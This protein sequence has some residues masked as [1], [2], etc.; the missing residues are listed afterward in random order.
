[1]L[2]TPPGNV[3][4]FGT[5]FGDIGGEGV[6]IKQGLAMFNW[7]QRLYGPAGLPVDQ[8]T[9]ND[10]GTIT[11][12]NGIAT[13]ELFGQ[14]ASVS[15]AGHSLGGHLAMM[16]GRMAPGI[17]NDVYTY[18]SPGFDGF[19]ADLTSTVFFEL[20][21]SAS[22]PLTG[23]IGTDWNTSGVNTNVDSDIVHI[24]GDAPGNSGTIFS[25]SNNQGP[26]DSHDVWPMTDALAVYNLFGSLDASL[27][28]EDITPFLEAA[29][30]QLNESLENIVNSF[31]VLFGVSG[32]VAVDNRDDLYT[33]IQTIQTS[34]LF[35]SSIGAVSI[36]DTSSLSRFDQS[37]T[38]EGYAY[39][40]A[41]VNL[42]P[43][44]ISGNAGLY[45]SS[46][47]GVESFT[48]QYLDDRAHMLDRLIE[49]NTADDYLEE[50][51][52]MAIERLKEAA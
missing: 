19:G 22:V 16:L 21:S 37:N 38:V 7:V 34:A 47:W 41:L 28:I 32:S 24:L 42:T 14:T 48:E 49:A 11:T 23:A 13:G 12:S 46:E 20:L 1:A 40:Y 3:D 9:Y 30:F 29:S 33:Q 8:Y 27:S 25:E 51:R 4:W 52:C 36:V 44:A 6:A 10:D 2:F 26:L 43:F 17:I 35:E 5:N 18:N 39:R 31:S 15:V 45:L 50:V